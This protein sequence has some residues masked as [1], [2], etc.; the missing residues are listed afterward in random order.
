MQLVL[1]TYP[2]LGKNFPPVFSHIIF[3]GPVCP[4]LRIDK[5]CKSVTYS[6]EVW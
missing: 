1:E 4:N 3:N 2:L 6:I 5:I